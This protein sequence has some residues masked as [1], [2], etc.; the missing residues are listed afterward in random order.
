MYFEATCNH[1]G[2]LRVWFLGRKVGLSFYMAALQRGV[3]SITKCCGL[4]AGSETSERFCVTSIWVQT[5]NP[6]TGQMVHV[7]WHAVALKGQC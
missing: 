1:I 2:G 4:L 7:H 5:L 3:G 6:E